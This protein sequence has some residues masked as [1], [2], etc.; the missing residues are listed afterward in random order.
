[1][2]AHLAPNASGV[3]V[4]AA[5]PFTPEG[6]V[7]H[8]SARRLTDFYLERGADGLTILGILGEQQKLSPDES[9]EFA[10]TVLAQ[11]A[12]RVPV[13]VGAA[14]PYLDN[15]R[16]FA[17]RMMDAGAAAI[18][19]APMPGLRSDD[20]VYGFYQ[21][22]CGTLSDIPVVV[23][24]Y[25]QTTGVFMSVAVINRVIN[26]FSNVV[27]LKHEDCPGLDK[28]SAVRER[29]NQGGRRVSI[30]VGNGALHYPQELARGADGA[31]TGFSY[32][33]M[34]VNV[35]RL[36]RAGRHQDAEDLFDA[37]LPLVRHEL[38][39]GVGLAI[40]KYVLMRRGAMSCDALRMPGPVLNQSGRDEVDRLIARLERRL[41]Q[42]D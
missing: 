27:M 29:A 8:D 16:S 5:T 24:D 13:I 36:W 6:T 35:L 40:R 18:M 3:Y 41:A 12:D 39:P 17:G 15:L 37:Y 28:L 4:I 10:Q 22:V 34:M 33:E 38:Q 25:P 14:S 21:R 42:L 31:M 11:V 19:V 26:D 30:L 20:Q 23:Q 32:P 7:D 1:M 9:F 2:S